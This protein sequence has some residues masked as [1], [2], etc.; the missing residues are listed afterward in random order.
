MLSL[1]AKPRTGLVF[2]FAVLLTPALAL[3]DDVPDVC[4]QRQLT[5]LLLVAVS[6]EPSVGLTFWTG[7]G[8]V[9]PFHRPP[10]TSVPY[11]EMTHPESRRPPLGTCWEIP[12]CNNQCTGIINQNFCQT[13][14]SA[15]CRP[16]Y[17][18]SCGTRQNKVDAYFQPRLANIEYRYMIG[19]ALIRARLARDKAIA[20]IK[21]EYADTIEENRQQAAEFARQDA[22]DRLS[23]SEY[24]SARGVIHWPGLFRDDPRFVEERR[25]L[26]A[27]FARRSPNTV[28]PAAASSAEIR[29]TIGR[30][31]STL[32][33]MLREGQVDG[34]TYVAAKRFLCSLAY[35]TQASSGPLPMSVVCN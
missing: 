35:E 22:P 11:G 6:G 1:I 12:G 20:D 25:L 28:H 26:D 31:K 34:T 15:R 2:L 32:L 24:D 21:R 18:T 14:G 16:C 5:T 13:A 8:G 10:P 4:L 17:G 27:L 7:P 3:A 23:P 30:M 33:A 29:T 9:E 19:P